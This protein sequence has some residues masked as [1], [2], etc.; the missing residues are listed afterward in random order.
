MMDFNAVKEGIA[1]GS[2]V[3][4]DVRNTDEVKENGKIPKSQVVPLPEITD[5]FQL[6]AEGFKSKYGFDKPAQDAAIVTHCLKGGRA[7][8]AKE[9]LDSQ[10]FSNVQVYSGSFT[11]WK[12]QGGDIENM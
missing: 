1:N 8:K 5:A 3:L 2:F 4:L 11:D 12:A 6:D 9:A 10:G 7:A